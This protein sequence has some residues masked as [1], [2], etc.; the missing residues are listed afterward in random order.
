[1][2][3]K[4][5]PLF[6]SSD[7]LTLW[8]ILREFHVILETVTPCDVYTGRYLEIIQKRKEAKNRTLAERKNY[9]RIAREQGSGL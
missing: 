2:V 6:S 5:E 3:D 1:M 4:K 7:T 9:N 8:S